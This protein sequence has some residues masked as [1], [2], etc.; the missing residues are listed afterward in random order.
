MKT[1]ALIVAAG[2]STRMKETKQMMKFGPYTMLERI[3]RCFFEAGVED[4]AI[5]V[6]YRAEE[7]QATLKDYPVTFLQ[8]PDYA[9]TQMFDSVKIGLRHWQGRCDRVLFCPVDASAFSMDTLERLLAHREDW[10]YPYCDGK[11]G[12]P[13]L[14]G[15]SLLPKILAHNGERGLKGALDSLGISPVVMEVTDAGSVMDADTQEDY[16]RM[17]AYLEQEDRSMGQADS[18]KEERA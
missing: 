16:R 3:V 6:G 7:I 1:G 13:I 18:R 15:Q 14:I 2:M 12:H 4:V 17:K 9:V 11:I 5:V 10:V 8:N